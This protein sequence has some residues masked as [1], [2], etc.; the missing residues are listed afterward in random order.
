MSF[1]QNESAMLDL[2]DAFTL[3]K[4][5]ASDFEEKYAFTWRTYRDSSALHKADTVTQRFFDSVFSLVDSFCSDPELI[6]EDGLTED[7]LLSEIARLKTS[8]ESTFLATT[9]RQ[10]LEV[11]AEKN[12]DWTWMILDRTLATRGIPGFGNVANIV[13]RLVNHGM[14]DVVC[15]ENASGPRYRVSE[16][17]HQLLRQSA[18]SVYRSV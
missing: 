16:H 8:R 11:M 6:D 14:V 9:E 17:G 4:M 1:N 5:T 2:I 18:E 15:N 3:G 10:V 7:E 13:T 12:I